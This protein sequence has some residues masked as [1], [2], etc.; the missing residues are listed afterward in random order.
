MGYILY[1]KYEIVD[2]NTKKKIATHIEPKRTKYADD[3]V[4]VVEE[5]NLV[6]GNW[7]PLVDEETW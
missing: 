3:G 6:R 4:T 7:E 2:T 5:G 1:G